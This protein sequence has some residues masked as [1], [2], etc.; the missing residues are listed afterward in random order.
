MRVEPSPRGARFVLR[1][2]LP[3][4]EPTGARTADTGPAGEVAATRS[5]RSAGTAP[6]KSPPRR[7]RRAARAH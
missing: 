6:A 1:L 4:T 7:S 2:P 5:C 3:G